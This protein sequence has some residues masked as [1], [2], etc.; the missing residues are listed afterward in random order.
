[1]L[2]PERSSTRLG[3]YPGDVDPDE[4][5]DGDGG[6]CVVGCCC[7][8][9]TV[10]GGESDCGITFLTGIGKRACDRLTYAHNRKKETDKNNTC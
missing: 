3:E 5:L 7:C 6:P 4:T 9:G 8:H 2:E 10:P 1:M